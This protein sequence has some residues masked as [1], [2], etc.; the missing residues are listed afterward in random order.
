MSATV[1]KSLLL[2]ELLDAIRDGFLMPCGDDDALLAVL[3]AVD[4]DEPAT[5]RRAASVVGRWRLGG[6]VSA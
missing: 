3:E 2:A 5:L 4:F 1:A 6:E